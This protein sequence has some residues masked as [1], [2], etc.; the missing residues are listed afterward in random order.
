MLFGMVVWLETSATAV[1][2]MDCRESAV[3][4]RKHTASLGEEL[5]YYE[6]N[7]PERVKTHA[8]QFALIGGQKA[9]GF[10]PSYEKAFEAG[11][12]SF[13]LEKQFLI[14]QVVEQ[15]PVFVIY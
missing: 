2:E 9:A 10:F 1:K 3:M 11:L 6:S 14:R 15:E 5:S 4:T 7:K 13:G 8:G 12:R